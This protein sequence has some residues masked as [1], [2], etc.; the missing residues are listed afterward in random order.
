M[1][2]TTAKD[3]DGVAFLAK[4]LNDEATMKTNVLRIILSLEET[5]LWMKWV[6]GSDMGMWMLTECGME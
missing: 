2:G 5:L 3:V 1:S 6:R 4:R